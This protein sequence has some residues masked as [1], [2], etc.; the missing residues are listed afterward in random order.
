MRAQARSSTF[1][2]MESAGKASLDTPTEGG[3]EGQSKRA[4]DY[5]AS[6]GHNG[7]RGKQCQDDC[8]EECCR[9]RD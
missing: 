2:V 1:E 4:S 8:V 3:G 6:R 9:R 7:Q 5:L